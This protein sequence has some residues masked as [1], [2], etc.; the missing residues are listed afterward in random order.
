MPTPVL[1]GLCP[2]SRVDGRA[3]PRSG[4]IKIPLWF[5]RYEVWRYPVEKQFFSSFWKPLEDME[6]GFT[7]TIGE[8]LHFLLFFL[9]YTEEIYTFRKFHPKFEDYPCL[10]A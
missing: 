3:G 8:I 2:E 10:M 1:W 4:L 9:T 7:P 6:L 5:P